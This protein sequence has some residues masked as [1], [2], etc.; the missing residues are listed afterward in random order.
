MMQE[1]NLLNWNRTNNIQG[2]RSTYAKVILISSIETENQLSYCGN[3]LE[4]L[5]K[6]VRTGGKLISK[7]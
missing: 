3:T 2:V 7:C 5:E 1:N 6:V 4:L